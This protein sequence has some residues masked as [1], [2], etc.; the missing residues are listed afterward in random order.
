PITFL[1]QRSN[2]LGQ[3]ATEGRRAARQEMMRIYEITLFPNPFTGVNN[4]YPPFTAQVPQEALNSDQATPEY[5]LRK[6]GPSGMST[7]AAGILSSR[8]K[9]SKP[10]SAS[11]ERPPARRRLSLSRYCDFATSRAWS[12]TV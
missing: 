4:R 3:L 1:D 10:L 9:A 2:D 11:P 12:R 7:S 8:H 5:Q 6:I